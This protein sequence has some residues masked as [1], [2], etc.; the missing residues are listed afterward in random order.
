MS[1]RNSP[2]A[3]NLGAEDDDAGSEIDV[4]MLPRLTEPEATRLTTTQ[5][6]R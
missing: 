5:A 1:T 6:D 2:E 3:D 4:S